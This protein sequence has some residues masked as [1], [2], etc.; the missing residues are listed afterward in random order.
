VHTPILARAP[1]NW[2]ESLNHLIAREGSEGDGN[3]DVL[4]VLLIVL[5]VIVVA[6]AVV[7]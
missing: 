2:T 1:G 7:S 6:K 3:M 5:V 4:I